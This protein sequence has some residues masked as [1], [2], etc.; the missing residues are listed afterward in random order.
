MRLEI[1][2][3]KRTEQALHEAKN[4]L[5]LRVLERT[6]ELRNANEDLVAEIAQRQQAEEALQRNEAY[7]AEA[8][9]LSHTGSFG[10]H[11]SNG[12]IYWSEETFRIFDFEPTSQPTLERIL[13]RT[14]PD[15]RP[16]VQKI[17]DA[18]S[19]EGKDFDFER[20]LLMAD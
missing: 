16:L 7:L 14:H 2:E 5:E 4:N 20:R 8:Q 1:A 12:E 13:E 19:Q 15:D 6:A 3:R 10:W 9:R 17:I 18:A 11:V